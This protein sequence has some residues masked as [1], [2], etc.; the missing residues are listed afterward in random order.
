MG[1]LVDNV[2]VMEI[3]VFVINVHQVRN[4]IRDFETKKLANFI[5]V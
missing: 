3:F 4:F 2:K 1:V 5:F